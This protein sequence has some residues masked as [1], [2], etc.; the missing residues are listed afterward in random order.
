MAEPRSTIDALKRALDTDE[1]VETAC[2]LIRC[3]SVNPPG[4][5]RAAAEYVAGCLS[6]LN[7]EGVEFVEPAAD[8]VSIL[9]KWGSPGDRAIVWNGHLD[10]VPAGNEEE[11]T[12]PPFA[13]EV[14]GGRVWGRGAVDMKGPIACVLQALAI[15][16]RVGAR[17]NGQVLLQ[18]VADEE[19]GGANGTGYLAGQDKLGDGVAT[20]AICGE[21]TRLDAFVAARGRLWLEV[22]TFGVSA[23][24]AQ[25]D[26]GSNAITAMH[27]VLEGLQRVELP[28]QPHPLVGRA[29]L[30]P[31]MIQGGTA[32]NTVPDRCT[33]AIDRRFLPHESA[34]GARAQ[35]E[36]LLGELATSHG[37]QSEL[38][39][40]A[41]YTASEV[42]PR[43][44]IVRTVREA[45]EAAAG[46]DV[47]IGGMPGSTDARFLVEAGIP[48]VIFGPGDTDQAH[49]VDESILVTELEH[50]ALAY[51]A[52]IATFLD[53]GRRGTSQ[54]ESA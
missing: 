28:D 53:A 24:A 31:T 47:A 13:G 7:V 18:L 50:G 32:P 29:T 36:D 34:D 10:V 2:G 44:E 52:A 27:H 23:H 16:D 9:A 17:P 4:D 1:L 40:L 22:E 49:V 39:E 30:T 21:P 48:T 35:I 20:G 54:A 38:R 37:V 46:R 3:R 14:H 11:W 6:R 51:A 12:H 42:D 45:A 43:S 5:E 26:L 33:V 15:L 19:T 25:A 41:R 8:R